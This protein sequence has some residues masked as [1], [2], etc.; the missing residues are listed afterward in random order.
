MRKATI[1]VLLTL[2]LS[3]CA[4]Y[5]FHHGKEPYDK[6]YVVSRDDYSILEYTIGQ[7]NTVPGIT[8]AK[9]RFNRRKKI[10][11]HYYK[12]MGFIENN[13]KKTFW[14]PAT[15]FL[16]VA[17]GLFRLPF[18][19]VSDY[20]YR[21]NPEYREKIRRLEDEKDT[22]EESRINK[23]KDELN[24]YIQQDLTKENP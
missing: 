5:K 6:G 20:K 7:D 4:T 3:G 21:H 10:V 18:I 2:F 24:V 16:K 14:N 12:K 13:F 11:E 8:L 15:Y 9:E 19:V 23:I 22:Q 17:G 1:F